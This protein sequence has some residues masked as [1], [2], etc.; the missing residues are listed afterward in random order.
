MSIKCE[1]ERGFDDFLARH[2]DIESD[3]SSRRSDTSS[4]RSD[5]SSRR[6]DN[7]PEGGSAL[8]SCGSGGAGPL[9]MISTPLSRPIP[10]ASVSIDTS[11]LCNPRILLT[12]TSL[13]VLPAWL[14]SRKAELIP[15]NLPPVQIEG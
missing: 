5:T 12:F 1:N 6:S 11:R 4:R 15:P 13:I 2:H 3:T 10:V 9:A 8:L 14:P 7:A